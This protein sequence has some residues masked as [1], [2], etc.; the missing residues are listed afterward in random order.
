M[1]TIALVSIPLLYGSH[2]GHEFTRNNP[3]DI[4]VFD[5]LIELVLLHIER[6]EIIPFKFDGVL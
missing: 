5:S 1:V 2:K 4:T 3:V 6:S